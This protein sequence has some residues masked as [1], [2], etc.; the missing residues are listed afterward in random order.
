MI[1][2]RIAAFLLVLAATPLVS[3]ATP[4]FLREQLTVA[5]SG[6]AEL[7]QLVWDGRPKPMCGPEDVDMA[8]TCPCSGWAY[9]EV[10]KLALVRRQGGNE[11]DRMDLGPLFEDLPADDSAGLAAMQW[12]PMAKGDWD[13]GGS[14]EPGFLDQVRR[15]A[16][17]RAMLLYDYDH[18]G[19]ATEFLIQVATLPCGTHQYA[20]VGV[21][22]ANPRLHA[23]S[24]EGRPLVLPGNVWQALARRELGWLTVWPCGDHGAETRGEMLANARDGVITVRRREIGC[25]GSQ[26]GV[27]VEEGSG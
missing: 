25:E 13:G 26:E 21:S 4:Q 10:G 22:K 27:V 23:L 8:M 1:V 7:W 12:R 16:G 15:R 2:R 3:A 24:S 17:P 14:E 18:D 5:V 19:A 20:A 11:I 6:K 9:G